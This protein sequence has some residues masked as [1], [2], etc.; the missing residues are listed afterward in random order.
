MSKTHKTKPW[1]GFHEIPERGSTVAET[2]M[3]HALLRMGFSHY[4]PVAEFLTAQRFMSERNVGQGMLGLLRETLATEGLAHHLDGYCGHTADGQCQLQKII[5]TLDFGKT[6]AKTTAN[7][8]ANGTA[9]RSS[10]GEEEA[11]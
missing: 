2:R 9:G 7:G 3:C 10:A 1:R 6:T 5:R 11:S 4:E 8:P